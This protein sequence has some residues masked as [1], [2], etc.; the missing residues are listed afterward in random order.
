MKSTPKTPI[1]PYETQSGKPPGKI[2]GDTMHVAKVPLKNQTPGTDTTPLEGQGFSLDT[3][4][5]KSV[6][7][8]TFGGLLL[9]SSMSYSLSLT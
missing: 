7:G 5:V 9:M 8:A 6:I 4:F 3:D 1:Q 2:G